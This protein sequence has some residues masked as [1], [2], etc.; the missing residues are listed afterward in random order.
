VYILIGLGQTVVAMS[1]ITFL[2]KPLGKRPIL[3]GLSIHFVLWWAAV[4]WLW[5]AKLS[6]T[7]WAGVAIGPTSY[8]IE[9]LSSGYQ[10][11]WGAAGILIS[12]ALI[13]MT[14]ISVRKRRCWVVLLTHVAMLLYWGV[15]FVLGLLAFFPPH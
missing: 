5:P 7:D 1:K 4:V 6:W 15:C 13:G 10:R 11:G 14:L 12:F 8:G 3:I 2:S 9:Y